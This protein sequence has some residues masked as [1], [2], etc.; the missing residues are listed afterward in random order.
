MRHVGRAVCLR[1]AKGGLSDDRTS[2]GLGPI[3]PQLSQHPATRA[4]R[5][6]VALMG[7]GGGSALEKLEMCHVRRGDGFGELDAGRAT[8]D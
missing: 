1:L 2:L 7:A 8:R 5:R 6:R 3:A 4:R